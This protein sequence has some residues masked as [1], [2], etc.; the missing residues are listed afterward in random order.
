MALEGAGKSS[1][2]EYDAFAKPPFFVLQSPRGGNNKIVI[3]GFWKD[4]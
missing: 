1:V 2:V 3:G 4:Y